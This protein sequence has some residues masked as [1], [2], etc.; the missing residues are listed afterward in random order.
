MPR[1]YPDWQ[2]CYQG[3]HFSKR[4]CHFQSGCPI[5]FRFRI[6]DGNRKKITEAINRM[7]A[8][9][10]DMVFC[11]SGMSVD[12][13]DKT[14]LAIKN[15]GVSVVSYGVLVLPGS[16]FLIAYTANGRPVCV[17][18]SCRSIFGLVL[19]LLTADIP[20]TPQCVFGK[21]A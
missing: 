18:Y 14:P 5:A 20:V 2:R 8:E 10:S 17:M 19:P 15:T 6:P 1:C 4:T 11:T 21:G 16:M 9:R 7:L 3:C 13:D 12:P